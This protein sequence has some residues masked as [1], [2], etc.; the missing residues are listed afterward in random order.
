MKK[1]I[2][3]FVFLGLALS[4][5]CYYDNEE[6]LY[7][8]VT[9][10]CDTIAVSYADDIVP[11]LQ[12]NCNTDGCHKAG[13]AGN[14]IFENYQAVK[15]KVDNGSMQARVIDQRTMP[16]AGTLSDCQIAIIQVWLNDGAADN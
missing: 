8:F 13:G 15:A 12:A 4:Q 6:E 16:P 14:G 11:L 2:V 1:L 7:Q 3:P 9:G 10:Q 5:G